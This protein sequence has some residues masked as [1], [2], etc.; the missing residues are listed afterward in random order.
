MEDE[1]ILDDSSI[2]SEQNRSTTRRRRHNQ[3]NT[4]TSSSYRPQ[5]E[6]EELDS[7]E[8]SNSNKPPYNVI[9][10]G[11]EED[12][13][14][15]REG[16]E[17]E[18]LPPL[19]LHPMVIFIGTVIKKITMPFIKVLFAPKAQRT[20]IK[21]AIFMVVFVWILLTSITAYL[22]FYQHYVP[23]TLHKESIYFQ[24]G[25]VG[26]RNL[27]EPR[28]IVDFTHGYQKAPLRHE[29]AYNVF[30]QLHVPTSDINFNLGNFMVDVKLLTENETVLA[31]SSRP[32]ILRYQSHTQRILHVLAK[33]FPL[34]IGFTEESQVVVVPLMEGYIEKKSNPFVKASVS[35]S[36]PDL[37]IYDAQISIRA[38]FRG[39]RYYMY[40]RRIPTAISFIILFMVIEFIFTTIAWKKYGQHLWYKLQDLFEEAALEQQ[41]YQQQLAERES[42]QQHRRTSST[43][44]LVNKDGNH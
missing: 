11:D 13:E 14:E 32:G 21:S 36:N 23:R 31:H 43:T 17:D 10:S 40:Y 35:I 41:A 22:T 3:H 5:D 25:H 12:E 30:V 1:D 19:E 15:E 7:E 38:D 37:Q 27:I 8:Y 34:L 18:E 2:H 29:Q 6:V 42:L 9:D 4:A 26:Q 33:A 24:Y 20:M 28:G 39:L 16:E 44:N